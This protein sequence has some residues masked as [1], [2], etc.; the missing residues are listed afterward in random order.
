ME[1]L[2]KLTKFKDAFANDVAKG[3]E[4]ASEDVVGFELKDIDIEN[5]YAQ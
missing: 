4:N 1:V 3:V 2:E 5:C